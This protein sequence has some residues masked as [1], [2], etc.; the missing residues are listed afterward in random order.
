[1]DMKM[2]DS[3]LI[4]I[5]HFLGFLMI[6]EVEQDDEIQSIIHKKNSE[7]KADGIGVFNKKFLEENLDLV[8][9]S[10]S[11][12]D[13][14]YEGFI[15]GCKQLI[16]I[17]KEFSDNDEMYQTI[18]DHDKFLD[19][20]VETLT[21]FYPKQI[22]TTLTKLIQ[23]LSYGPINFTSRFFS[24]DI[25]LLLKERI[26]N[27][28]EIFA[29]SSSIQNEN[30]PELLG[31][32]K[33][34]KVRISLLCVICNLVSDEIFEFNII[35]HI[36]DS[37][38]QWI[39]ITDNEVKRFVLKTMAC[40]TSELISHCNVPKDEFDQ[41]KQKEEEENDE[42]VALE[43]EKQIHEMLMSIPQIFFKY[44]DPNNLSL[45]NEHINLFKSYLELREFNDDVNSFLMKILDF[46]Y[47]QDGVDETQE[48]DQ[49]FQKDM[50]YNRKLILSSLRNIYNIK[51]R[52]RYI[53]SVV[54]WEKIYF[55]MSQTKDQTCLKDCLY[56]LCE[57][58]VKEEHDIQSDQTP[59][60]AAG[61]FDP[62]YNRLITDFPDN[63]KIEVQK[64]LL[65]TINQRLLRE[66]DNTNLDIL[67]LDTN[68]LDKVEGMALS[69]YTLAEVFAEIYLRLVQFIT[70][71][72]FYVKKYSN[73]LDNVETIH[74][75]I[76]EADDDDQY[77]NA[78]QICQEILSILECQEEE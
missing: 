71:S 24:T 8:I 64:L 33:E 55:F 53:N 21:I 23:Y 51:E 29:F 34:R 13:D 57:I 74:D 43:Q 31:K 3:F 1:M 32:D 36:M 14:K 68:F 26:D 30:G 61:V 38:H 63:T 40:L 15:Y 69:D 10:I 25:W 62:L 7:A 2:N 44:L 59:G 78:A 5:R 28:S 9:Y 45:F 75:I 72:S 17:M 66:G 41:L 16:E 19:C 11:T 49:F 67:I 47:S 18:L 60:V 76:Q 20:L 73:I 12:P 37:L 42:P 48:K 52:R 39:D 4:F 58:I 46:A 65:F 56:T 35:Q 27:P 50:D 6:G 22:L 77:E 54:D 70:T